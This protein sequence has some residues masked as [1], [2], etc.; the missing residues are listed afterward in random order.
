MLQNLTSLLG[1]FSDGATTSE[2]RRML[3]SRVRDLNIHQNGKTTWI[4]GTV[5][6]YD[7][8]TATIQV[9]GTGND[10]QTVSSCTCPQG[11]RTGKC[12]HLAAVLYA[13]CIEV[14]K[15]ED[16]PSQPE[17]ESDLLVK[18]VIFDY[19]NRRRSTEGVLQLRAMLHFTP[20]DY[21]LLSLE[22]G[23]EGVLSPVPNIQQFLA[24]LDDQGTISLDRVT[25]LA[26]KMESF[27]P[28][29]QALLRYL[30]DY[31]LGTTTR[32]EPMPL[33]R[34]RVL[35]SRDRP[36]VR[37]AVALTG[38]A[39]DRLFDVLKAVPAI[40]DQKGRPITVADGN[41]DTAFKLRSEEAGC[42]LDVD[43]PDILLFGNRSSTYARAGGTLYRVTQEYAD[44]VVPF[45]RSGKKSIWIAGCDMPI[46]CNRIL[47]S[48][49]RNA[50]LEDPADMMSQFKPQECVPLFYLDL[51]PE[52]NVLTLELKFR[53]G[54]IVISADA[55]DNTAGVHRDGYQ[56][57]EIRTLVKSLFPSGVQ[58]NKYLLKGDDAIF[59]MLSGK[60]DR[61]R[62]RGEI[63][64][65]DRL[66]WRVNS[67]STKL[68]VRVQG[69][70]LILDIDTGEFPPEEMEELYQSLLQRRRFYRLRDGRYLVLSDDAAKAY[71]TLAEMTHLLR[72]P[73]DSLKQGEIEVPAFRAL[74]LESLAESADL[75]VTRDNQFRDMIRR[76]RSMEEDPIPVPEAMES[77]LRPYQKIGFQWLKTLESVNFGGVLADEMGLGKTIEMI[78]YFCTVPCSVTG[79]PSLVIC[80]T[81]LI[82]N[83]ADEFARFAPHLHVLTVLGNAG[84]RMTRIRNGGQ[85]D[86]WVTSYEMLRQDVETYAKLDF[87]CCVLDEAQ[88][89]KNRSTLASNAVKR[90]RCTQ[91]FVMTGTPIENRLSELWNLFDFL[92]PGYLF[93]HGVFVEKLEKPVLRSGDADA[94]MQL[95]RMVQPFMLRRL[96]KDVL[97]ELPPKIEHIHRIV[98]SEEERKVYISTAVD[99]KRRLSEAHGGTGKV[100]VLAALMRLRQV[101]CSPLLAYENYAGPNSK[102]VACF[103]LCSGMVENGHQILLFSQFTSMLDLLRNRLESAGITTYTLEGSTSKEM[104]AKL[105]KSFN[106][107]GANVFLISLKA[108]GTGLNLTAA[109]VVIHYD[110]WW[111]TAAQEQATDRAHRIGQHS[112]VQVYKLICQN[113]LEEQIMELQQRKAAL[114]DTV[115]STPE[116]SLASMSREELLALLG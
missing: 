103:E 17:T 50:T 30:T 113:T 85:M 51:R 67:T 102:L 49:G 71:G 55:W 61:L 76:F 58:D 70:N 38:G 6:L 8:D 87:Y 99:A 47:P 43:N 92:M 90:I 23:R 52:D 73:L 112:A 106:E 18:D 10:L 24:K 1:R 110:P 15:N 45:L 26:L 29:A 107:G 4:R 53:Y 2:K 64:V 89:V 63:F 108:G 91:R 35:P 11:T 86:V 59:D 115:S 83:W 104:R 44:T 20:N 27:P 116:E 41:P 69:G 72:L 77:V 46:L 79:K 109:D 74:Y 5:V 65:S 82:L 28:G 68:G 57:E 19:V 48:L 56:E 66:N 12:E 78:A 97:P 98:L 31:M 111:N 36:P 81:S 84:E 101:C 9:S 33:E 39:F 95:R 13:A 96:K 75:T 54:E 25:T 80:P 94:A 32:Q 100:D 114:M 7:T 3:A 34:G 16:R 21:P 93:T 42:W 37:S 40:Q 62:E 88:Y 14:Q 60:L 105:V 22:V